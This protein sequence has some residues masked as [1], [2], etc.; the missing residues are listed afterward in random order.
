M[1]EDHAVG[2]SSLLPPPARIMPPATPLNPNWDH[3]QRQILEKLQAAQVAMIAPSHGLASHAAGH[4]HASVASFMASSSSSAAASSTSA[5]ATPLSAPGAQSLTVP[6]QKKRRP[7]SL[8]EYRARARKR[9]KNLP[10]S[11]HL[12][13]WINVSPP[14]ASMPHS[15]Q[16]FPHAH[17]ASPFAGPL[18]TI[19]HATGTSGA[20][21]SAPLQSQPP[22]VG[23]FAGVLAPADAM[24]SSGSPMFMAHASAGQSA[25]AARTA[26]A[27]TP[28][29]IRHGP[30]A[31][32][33][34]SVSSAMHHHPSHQAHE[35]AMR[36][37]QEQLRNPHEPAS[38]KKRVRKKEVGIPPVVTVVEPPQPQPA[39][40]KSPFV[41]RS[42]SGSAGS[43]SDKQLQQPAAAVSS[44][45]DLLVAA[46]DPAVLSV[47]SS[48]NGPSTSSARRKSGSG[49]SKSESK[50]GDNTELQMTRGDLQCAVSLLTLF[51]RTDESS[52][53]SSSSAKT[54]S[55]S[56][57][58]TSDNAHAPARNGNNTMVQTGAAVTFGEAVVAGSTGGSYNGNVN[59]SSNGGVQTGAAV[60]SG[61]A[62]SVT[63]SITIHPTF[64]K[65]RV[66]KT[67]KAVKSDKADKVAR[68][69]KVEGKAELPGQQQK[70]RPKR[71]MRKTS[72]A[73]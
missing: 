48:A 68:P 16:L 47:S 55:T 24:H 53:K 49:R 62:A 73:L 70:A 21:T 60:T 32:L 34:P 46:G 17:P 1:Q 41:E 69:D 59:S 12:S 50:L 66:D 29:A 57:D 44:D 71:A 37:S 35:A 61:E 11:L 31:S 23:W 20:G 26:T 8:P 3:D 27:A 39:R 54:K 56:L 9:P 58:S 40:A 45:S 63:P 15:P 65:K 18:T 64:R 19:L 67:R 72:K 28:T 5:P 38:K 33:S 43:K 42:S 13:P 2:A 25:F 14:P 6:P 52:G 10:S 51:G 36:H 30:A 4:S 7:S 22:Q